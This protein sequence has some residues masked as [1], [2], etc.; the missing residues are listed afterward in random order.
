M[1]GFGPGTGEQKKE[2]FFETQIRSTL[3][4]TQHLMS[5]FGP[6]Q[7]EH[8]RLITMSNNPKIRWRE[9]R[10]VDF[11]VG[12]DNQSRA[13]QSQGQKQIQFQVEGA[14]EM[15]DLHFLCACFRLKNSN[16]VKQ[17]RQNVRKK[18][19]YFNNSI[20][21]SGRNPGVSLVQDLTQRIV[22]CFVL[23]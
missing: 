9:E 1:P 10:T 21:K 6:Y 15:W 20:S 23:L 2:D 12:H 16:L 8:K 11:R 18:N 3:C 17:K 5:K 13:R 22:L 4:M 14:F 19:T 7:K